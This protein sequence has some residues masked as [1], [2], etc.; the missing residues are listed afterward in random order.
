LL[1]HKSSSQINYSFTAAGGTYTPITGGTAVTLVNAGVSNATTT[2][3]GYAN[4]IPLG[5]TLNYNGVNYTAAH[6][7]TNGF[8]AFGTPFT[9]ANGYYEND[10]SAGPV[11]FPDVR[12][13]IAPLWDD[14]DLTG[15]NNIT[16][17]TSGA[18]PNRVFTVQYSNVLWDYSGTAG[19]VISFQV[20][21]YETSN[22]IQFIYQQEASPVVNT[23][24]GASIGITAV[25]TGSSNFLSL[26]DA[27]ASPTASTIVS[28]D[29]ISV[30]P[31]TGQV[32]TFTPVS[33]FAPAN[34]QVTNI[35][36]ASATFSWDAV[37]GATGY[38]Y[39]VST[40]VIE[41]VSGTAT[42][43]T[44]VNL[45]TLTPASVNYLYVRTNCGS[46]FSVWVRKIVIPCTINTAPA[47]NA[48]NVAVPTTISWSP[49]AGATGYNIMFS[50]DGVSFEDIGTTSELITSV[51][52]P[53]SY[54]T[55]YYYY[56]RAVA[57]SDTASV[58]CQSNATRFTTQGPPP[59]P[60]NDSCGAATVISGL[61]GIVRGYTVGATPSPNG[62][63]CA[64]AENDPPST[65]DDDVWYSFRALQ[66]G[67][68]TITVTGD[69]FFDAVVSA[70][71]GTCGNLKPLDCIDTTFAG[72]TERLTLTNLVAGETYYIRVYDWEENNP[73][74][75][76]ISL[77][78]PSLPVGITQFTGEPQ[79][80][81]NVLRWIIAT[82]QNNKG[83]EIQRSV[84]GTNFTSIGFVASKFAQG[85][86]ASASYSF[87]DAKP[88]LNTNH[89]RLK[90][91]D[92]DGRATHTN[93]VTLKGQR[94]ITLQ[95]SRL[96]PNPASA[97]LNLL[98]NAPANDKISIVITDFAGRVVLRQLAGIIAGDNKLSL[99][100]TQLS[101]GSYMIKT[102]SKGGA[103]T[104]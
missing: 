66:N 26:S 18:A 90:Q 40:S 83:F 30:K 97:S 76:T 9:Q 39:S 89:Y 37:T 81:K 54:S 5:F 59:L 41:P 1:L 15:S 94:P 80:S 60:V 86:G 53:T 11:A 28:T 61:S 65:A 104:L 47:N 44:S 79:G 49:V 32:Y 48:T 103:E 62:D 96:Y 24:L 14:L 70:Y 101:A 13:V 8:I 3:E 55:I 87:D 21:F 22:I 4:N 84:D 46:S 93:I 100:I 68:V 95:L 42:T 50:L 88:F 16:Y 85:S 35:A 74:T 33:C 31:A 45:T 20:K 91:V 43:A 7:N 75:F 69:P 73:G 82:E 25:G 98:F 92:N 36:S 58:A 71:S 10:L 27:G 6:I 57:G 64:P 72:E 78:G 19:P 2:D 12:P 63:I 29:T 23:S 34:S 38:E 67:S 102:V 56:V 77:T 52:L 17:L 51:P 99:N